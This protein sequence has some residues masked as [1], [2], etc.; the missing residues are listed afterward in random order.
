[1]YVS[2]EVPA[3]PPIPGIEEAI[4]QSQAARDAGGSPAQGAIIPPKAIPWLTG[5]VAV[6]LVASRSLP[7]HTIAAQVAGG[8]VDVAVLLGLASP[9]WRRK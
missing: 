4:Q 3:A 8:L 9:G 1:M 7:Q 5:L 6:A 2:K